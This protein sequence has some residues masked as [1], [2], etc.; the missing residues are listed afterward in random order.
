[1]LRIINLRTIEW[2]TI[3]SEIFPTDILVSSSRRFY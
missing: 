1:M 3:N 2:L